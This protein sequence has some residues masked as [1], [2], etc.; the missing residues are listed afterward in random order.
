VGELL[1]F[2]GSVPVWVFLAAAG[3]A[4]M[5]RALPVVQ[6]P[7]RVADLADRARVRFRAAA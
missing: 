5:L 6:G 7:E 4:S 1:P 2:S 3:L